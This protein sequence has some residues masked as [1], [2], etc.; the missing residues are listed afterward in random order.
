[1]QKR[2]YMPNED[3]LEGKEETKYQQMV[4]RVWV[5]LRLPKNFI[6]LSNSYFE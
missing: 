6:V 5:R 2:V 3:T 1:M 4:K